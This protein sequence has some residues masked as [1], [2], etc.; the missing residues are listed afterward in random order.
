M[1]RS[2]SQLRMRS[3]V[4]R[5]SRNGFLYLLRH[6][7]KSSRYCGSRYSRYVGV[8]RAGVRVGRDDRV[9]IRRSCHRGSP[10]ARSC[11]SCSSGHR[12]GRNVAR[13]STASV[14]RGQGATMSLVAPASRQ[15]STA[16][17]S[18][19]RTMT[20]RST[21]SKS[22]SRAVARAA[23]AVD[24]G[25]ERRSVPEHRDPAVAELGGAPERSIGV[26][27]DVDREMRLH[28]LGL[29]DDRT[30][31]VVRARVLDHR[32]GPQAPADL[33]ALVDTRAACGE[34]E[35]DRLPLG[36]RASSRR[37]RG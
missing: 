7:S 32:L 3:L 20:V 22:R 23:E 33:D 16:R 15:A 6:A 21:D 4:S 37:R 31:L 2:S 10:R 36:T 11:P 25:G 1:R 27:A 35:T 5:R 12:W 19:S 28:R 30:E 24:R 29:E 18:G 9:V 13:P 14:D 17:A 8:A 26:A 34:V